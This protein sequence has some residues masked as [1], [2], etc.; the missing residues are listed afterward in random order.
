MHKST[1]YTTVDAPRR[2]RLRTIRFQRS[3]LA[4]R[5]KSEAG[6]GGEDPTDT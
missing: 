4:Q 3:F 5:V 2:E 1:R 6:E